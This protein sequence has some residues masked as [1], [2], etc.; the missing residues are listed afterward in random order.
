M[1]INT[2]MSNIS[3][4]QKEVANLQKQLA[5]ESRKETQLLGKVN[6]V[7]RS[8]NNATSLNAL[9]SKMS[10][11]TNYNNDM[12]KCNTK[13]SDINKNIA[14]KNNEL[15]R[16]Q[17]QLQKEQE[18]ELKKR[19][20][21]QKKLEKE[22]LEYQNKIS[23]GL[24]IQK[25]IISNT[26]HPIPINNSTN[27]AMIEK[28]D[29]FI[30]HATED[31][32]AFVRPLAELLKNR[33]IKVWYDEFS[34]G[35]GS[36]LRKTIDYGLV[37]SRFGV[38]IISRSFIKKQWTEYE[39]NGLTA[40]EMNGEN[41]VILPIWHEVSKSDIIQFSPS[42]ADKVALNSS[43]YTIEEIAEELTALLA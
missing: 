41:K 24:D 15:N 37:N 10:Q 28:Y 42:L 40:R 27:S 36:S 6:Q 32:E 4:V 17:T 22:Q 8:I 30:S 14:K 23:R 34:L 25:N 2:T 39:L 43:M 19:N 1:S 33:G 20:V 16:L 21:A 18:N 5:D 9:A 11:I 35:W 31:K 12:S 26:S 29:V 3:R 38:V 13:K 7:H